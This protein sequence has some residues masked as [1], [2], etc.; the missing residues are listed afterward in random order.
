LL[1]ACIQE[2]TDQNWRKHPWQPLRWIPLNSP[3]ARNLSAMDKD[4]DF[5]GWLLVTHDS[6]S[7][8]SSTGQRSI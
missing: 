8:H 5:L 3:S 1:L 2:T 6:E 4:A 7:V